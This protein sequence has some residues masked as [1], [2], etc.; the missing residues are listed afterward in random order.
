[1]KVHILDKW[2]EEAAEIIDFQVRKIISKKGSCSILLTG[3]RSGAKL[4]KAWSSRADFNFLSGINFY[5][6]DERCVDYKNASSNY[7]TVM[8]NLFS[9]GVPSECRVYRIKADSSDPYA[10]AKRYGK[11]L[12]EIID[13]AIFGIGDDGHFASLFPE[14]EALNEGVEKFKFVTAPNLPKQRITITPIILE[15]IKTIY[16]L[17][18]GYEKTLVFR[19]LNDAAKSKKITAFPALLISNAIWLLEKKYY[20]FL[21]EKKI[22]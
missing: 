7:D 9:K 8:R 18:P 2:A 12:P 20:S 10:E 22:V 4:Y 17:A 14:S 5:W 11:L 6:G 13:I 16:A 21:L 3:G 15:K 1:M 19:K